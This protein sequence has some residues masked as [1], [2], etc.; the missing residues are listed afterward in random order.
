VRYPAG[1]ATHS[2]DQLLY[3][4]SEGL[5]R[6]RDYQVDIA[7]GSPAVHYSDDHREFDGILLP[8]KRIVYRRDESGQRVPEPVIVTI[9]IDEVTLE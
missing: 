2:S 3:V 9:D 6:R 7:G 8:V 1:I 5:I 4:D